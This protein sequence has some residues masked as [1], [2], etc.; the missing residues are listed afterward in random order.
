MASYYT[1]STTTFDS[2]SFTYNPSEWKAVWNSPFE[3]EWIY[4]REKRAYRNTY[5]DIEIAE[6][7]L[8][9]INYML[10]GLLP[11][12]ILK[13]TDDLDRALK[14]KESLPKFK[15]VRQQNSIDYKKAIE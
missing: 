15:E 10:K 5:K 7:I 13:R 6:E 14:V 2:S 1:T 9:S 12:E 4:V 11:D 3:N 8:F